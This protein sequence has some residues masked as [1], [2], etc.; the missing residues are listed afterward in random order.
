MYILIGF[1]K[2]QNT[3]EVKGQTICS[4]QSERIVFWS[5][6]EPNKIVN[7]ERVRER[8]KTTVT[9]LLY[10]LEFLSKEWNGAK[11]SDLETLIRKLAWGIQI[12]VPLPWWPH[13]D[14]NDS[15]QASILCAHFSSTR[16]RKQALVS[17]WQHFWFE[18]TSNVYLCF[19]NISIT[20]F[21][22]L[23]LI[24]F[25]MLLIIKVIKGKIWFVK[26]YF[27]E[28]WMSQYG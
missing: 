28:V 4:S 12:Y 14:N 19:G 21:F 1:R 7:R 23:T 27:K 16:S 2:K 22:W 9:F 26:K 25:A 18:I 3:R 15:K 17:R 11:I 6:L 5:F 20:L 13:T 10:T 8:I 24:Y